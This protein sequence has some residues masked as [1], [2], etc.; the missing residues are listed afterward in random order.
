MSHLFLLAAATLSLSPRDLPLD[1]KSPIRNSPRSPP[2]TARCPIQKSSQIDPSA[3]SLP[4][5][6][7][8]PRARNRRRAPVSNR[9][10]ATPPRAT[11]AP[12]LVI[13]G[14]PRLAAAALSHLLHA[15]LGFLVVFSKTRTPRPSSSSDPAPSQRTCRQI[16]QLP[17]VLVAL[18]CAKSPAA[19]CSTSS[20]SGHRDPAS[21]PLT[22]RL[23]RFHPAGLRGLSTSWAAPR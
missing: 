9:P 13:A 15:G 20:S 19:S 14:N 10:A 18:P 2:I 22:F 23:G 12:S 3:A 16:R 8:R 1:P 17:P 11:S 21:L 7:S 5:V 6:S 4:P